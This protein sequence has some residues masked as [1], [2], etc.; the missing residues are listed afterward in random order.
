MKGTWY[1]VGWH[2][3]PLD[4]PPHQ[5]LSWSGRF[6]DPRSSLE[7]TARFRTLYLGRRRT[8]ALR[9]ALQDLRPDTRATADFKSLFG[10]TPP[11]G[12]VTAQWRADRRIA[13]ARVEGP[14]HV[15]VDLED[16]DVRR[17][18]EEQHASL[19][20]A[21]GM[22]HLDISQLRSTQRVVTQTIALELYAAG[23][24]GIAY[25]STLDN[26]RCLAVF[27]GRA[28]LT[29]YGSPQTLEA[30]DEDLLAVCKAWNLEIET[31]AS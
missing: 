3:G 27:E 10:T 18:L 31:V 19:L 5:F 22:R 1:R 23:T 12:I 25:R 8:T 9:E 4:Y 2:T 21:H 6:D 7:P 14:E 29:P 20:A 16:L 24:A 26:E 30:N 15:F 17:E 13:R 28:A 11:A